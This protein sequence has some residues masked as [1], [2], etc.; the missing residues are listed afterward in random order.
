MTKTG[1]T[2]I[3]PGTDETAALATKLAEAIGKSHSDIA[4][5]ALAAVF[6]VIL[7]KL[8]EMSVD[9]AIAAFAH[10]VKLVHPH[11]SAFDLSRHEGGYSTTDLT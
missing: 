9:E 5:P 10:N 11:V 6:A 4:L 2:F 7:H 3:M 1:D 8:P